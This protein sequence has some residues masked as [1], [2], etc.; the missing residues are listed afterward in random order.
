MEEKKF[1]STVILQFLPPVLFTPFSSQKLHVTRGLSLAVTVYHL[2]D[3]G[4]KRL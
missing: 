3:G 4:S 2:D 1:S